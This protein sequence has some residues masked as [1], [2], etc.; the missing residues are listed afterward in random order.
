MG[1]FDGKKSGYWI[2]EAKIFSADT[3]V[4]SVC[5]SKFSKMTS[6]C[7]KC[8]SRMKKSRYDPKWIDEL[9]AYDALFED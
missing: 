5:G 6:S 9:E 8:S 1:I 3:Y 7:P 4:C 2:H